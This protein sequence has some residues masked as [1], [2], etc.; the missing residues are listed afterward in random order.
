MKSAYD[1]GREML[2]AK[3]APM[4]KEETECMLRIMLAPPGSLDGTLTDPD[5]PF[6][7]KVISGRC[8]WAGV[9][10]DAKALM[11]LSLICKSPGDC[12]IIASDIGHRVRPLRLMRNR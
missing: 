12:M 9:Q 4:S 11:M 8:K 2:A 7:L 6:A 5:A 1:I 3:T 10:V